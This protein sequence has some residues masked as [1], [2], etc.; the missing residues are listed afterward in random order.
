MAMPFTVTDTGW[1][2][3][4]R[5]GEHAAAHDAFFGKAIE[6]RCLHLIASVAMDERIAVIIGEDE[7][8]V[9]LCGE[10]RAAD[11]EKE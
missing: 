8:D 9:R 7:E 5:T 10:G 3:L 6:V 4:W 2:T 11:Q 1:H